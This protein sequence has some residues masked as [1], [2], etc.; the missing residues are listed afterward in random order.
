[1]EERLLKKEARVLGIDDGPYHRGSKRTLIVMTVYRLDGY[2]DGFIAGRIATD[3]DDSAYVVS[4]LLGQSRFAPQIRAIISDGAC[5]GGFNVLDIDEVYRRTSLPVITVSDESPDTPSVRSALE[6]NFDDW[7]ERL[8]L[9]TRHPPREIQLPD[10]VCYLREKGITGE[11]ADELI[12]RCTVR[13]RT[14]EPVRL[15]HMIASAMDSEI[16]W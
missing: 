11:S 12:T 9:I 16:G 4:D 14:P 7:R 3:G 15:S 5:L 10:G 8:E 13:G 6:R 1:M 2:I